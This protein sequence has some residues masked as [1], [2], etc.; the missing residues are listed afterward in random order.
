MQTVSLP[1]W[2]APFAPEMGEEQ[3]HNVLSP[4]RSLY[5]GLGF[6]VAA[7]ALWIPASCLD[8]KPHIPLLLKRKH[9]SS[10]GKIKPLT[11]SEKPEHHLTI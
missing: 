3:Y 11:S 9:Y 8:H 6:A 1:S 7:A 2:T 5:K 10:P 4:K